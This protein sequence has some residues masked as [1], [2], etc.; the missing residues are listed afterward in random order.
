LL[1]GGAELL[2]MT[3][4]AA[5]RAAPPPP[6]E[7]LLVAV[8]GG[9]VARGVGPKPV[10]DGLD[11]HR[12]LAGAEVAG[13][14]Q[15]GGPHREHIVAVDPQGGIPNPVGR[16]AMGTVACTSTGSEIA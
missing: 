10:G 15:G 11:E 9:V 12:P 16:S 13:R 6:S 4:Q 7:L 8:A 1:D 3:L 5:Q 2:E 14:V